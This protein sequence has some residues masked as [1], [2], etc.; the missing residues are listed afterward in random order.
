MAITS[1]N[2]DIIQ[3]FNY[4][5]DAQT[6]IGHITKLQIGDTEYEP[7]LTV[8]D[9]TKIGN[10]DGKVAVV[11]V[12]SN[13]YWQ[14]GHAEAVLFNCRVSTENKKASILLQHT[15]L[16]K[17]DVVFSFVVY[18]YD[19]DK[20]EYYKSFHTTDTPLNGLVAKHGG[21]LDMNID[22]NQAIDVVSPK[23]YDFSLGVMPQEEEQQIENAEAQDANFSKKWGVT[24]VGK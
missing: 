17:T 9:P 10:D 7:D 22:T 14:G 1:I 16:S 12:L 5:K 20:K 24:V 3:G 11:G 19:P 13:I 8:Q 4:Q 15:S 23:N 2:C 6:L 21:Q 18:D